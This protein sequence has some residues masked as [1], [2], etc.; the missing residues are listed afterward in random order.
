[1]L[2]GK[3]LFDAKS[4]LELMQKHCVEPPPTVSQLNCVI[5]VNTELLELIL[6]AVAKPPNARPQTAAEFGDKLERVL[7]S[8]TLDKL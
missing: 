5:D 2:M 8:L 7:E 6:S 1:A 3:S 4:S